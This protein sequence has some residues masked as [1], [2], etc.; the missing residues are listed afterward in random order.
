[1]V[2]VPQFLHVS[3]DLN[4]Y[5]IK[6]KTLNEA[7]HITCFSNDYGYD[8]WIEEILKYILQNLIL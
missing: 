1:M 6:S 4:N 5:N 2:G 7:N 8:K 3:T